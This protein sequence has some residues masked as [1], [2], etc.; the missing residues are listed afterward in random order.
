MQVATARVDAAL[1]QHAVSVWPLGADDLE[2]AARWL[3]AD[4]NQ[5]W[6]DFGGGV[7]PPTTLSLRVMSQRDQHSIWVYGP[8]GC[9]RVPVG[10][11]GLGQI[12]HRFQTAEVW[13]VLGEKEYG[14]QD[15][16]VRAS[17]FV[18]EHGFRNLGLHCIYAWTVEVNRGARRLLR[19]FGFREAGRLR[20]SHL[21]GGRRY[22]RIWLDLLAEEY[23]GFSATW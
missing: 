11:V 22:D 3:A 15:L 4:R 13:C 12:Q 5:P 21:I 2:I 6:L 17:A 14:P 10:L 8:P 19:R 7:G 1:T 20:A 18:L 9:D 23:A 16:T